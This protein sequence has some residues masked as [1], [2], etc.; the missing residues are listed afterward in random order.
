M[1]NID[2]NVCNTED[3]KSFDEYDKKYNFIY[4]NLT[5]KHFYDWVDLINYHCKK[6]EKVLLIKNNWSNIVY[7]LVERNS[8][9]NVWHE[10]L[11]ND[12][13]I[14][15]KIDKEFDVIKKYNMLE[16]VIYNNDI[17]LFKSTIELYSKLG[18][19]TI[20]IEKFTCENDGKIIEVYE[21]IKTDADVKIFIYCKRT[22]TLSAEEQYKENLDKYMNVNIEESAKF[23]ADY[24]SIYSTTLQRHFPISFYDADRIV[25]E[26]IEQNILK[27]IE[28][29]HI[30][31]DKEKFVNY[32]VEEIPHCIK[33]Y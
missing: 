13:E 9:L 22:A 26:C 4:R 15:Y 33:Q 21:K 28:R 2:Y 14:D 10:S 5:S 19:K 30:I 32:I 3:V 16:I 1:E 25:K 11:K 8:G 12:F 31:V 23:I 17:E 20:F 6:G 24:L 7:K 18:Y 27:P 29:R